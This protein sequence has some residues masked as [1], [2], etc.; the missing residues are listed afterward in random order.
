M[1]MTPIP[2]AESVS[3]VS[4]TVSP[5]VARLRSLG[6]RL[7]TLAPSRICA[8]LND[9]NV[10]V[11]CSKKRLTAST[12]SSNRPGACRFEISRLLEDRFDFVG[13]KIVKIDEATSRAHGS[14]PRRSAWL[15]QRAR[16]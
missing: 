3:I 6:E 11:L 8:R 14:R 4:S 5:L 9:V 10:R 2:I 13:G 7:T 15:W 12:P 16:P 1:T